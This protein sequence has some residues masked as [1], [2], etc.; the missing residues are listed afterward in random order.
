MKDNILT[1]K[2]G[3]HDTFT[4]GK[5]RE[6]RYNTVKLEVVYEGE[7]KAGKQPAPAPDKKTSLLSAAEALRLAAEFVD[8]N[9]QQEMNEAAEA[10]ELAAEFL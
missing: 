2:I 6:W 9:K 1:V 8:G 3:S 4:I 7:K 5:K 10:L